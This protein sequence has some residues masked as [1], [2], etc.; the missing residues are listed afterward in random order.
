MLDSMITQRK[1]CSLH[2]DQAITSV[3]SCMISHYSCSWHHTGNLKTNKQVTLADFGYS[4]L[5]LLA[6]QNLNYLVFQSFDYER[7]WWR[8]FQKHVVRTKFDIYFFIFNNIPFNQRVS[9]TNMLIIL[10]RDI[11]RFVFSGISYTK[12]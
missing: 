3:L 7:T 5:C 11:R 2:N 12:C 10:L 6:P 1:M 8:L 4:V 9:K